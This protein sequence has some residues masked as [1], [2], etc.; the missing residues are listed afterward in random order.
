MTLQRRLLYRWKRFLVL[1]RR[2]KLPGFQGMGLYDVL[3]FFVE[4]LMD[5]KFTLLASA[6]AYQFF[7]SLIPALL[8]VFLILPRIPVSG[9]QEATLSFILQFIPIGGGGTFEGSQIETVLGEVV[10]NY[11]AD[12]TSF[13]LIGVSTFLALWG[14]TRGIIAMMKAFTKQEEVF[15]RRNVLELYGTAFLIFF[16]L[17]LEALIAATAIISLNNAWN[18]LQAE[19][20]MGAAWGGF[21]EQ[22]T[23]LIATAIAVFLGISTLYFF[24]P[25]TQER[26]KFLSPGSIAAGTL[27]LF[28]M[29][30]LKYYFSNFANFDKL[31]GSLGAIILLMVWFYYLSIMLLIGF[32][33]NAAI[34]IAS[35]RH[36]ASTEDIK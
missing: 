31:Y 14:A 4:A 33:L 8:L 5:A 21:I 23:W 28:A 29:L 26:W 1:L 35:H 20:I 6:M 10:A 17:A 15:K 18:F 27:T 34:D 3:R 32:E 24:A 7:F 11:Y 13:L 2:V 12:S 22:A 30:G 9:L 16:I 25:A 19:G 36:Q